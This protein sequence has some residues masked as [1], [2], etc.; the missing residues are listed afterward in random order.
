MQGHVAV[1]RH[2]IAV[3]VDISARD[4]V[5]DSSLLNACLLQ[6]RICVQERSTPLHLAC[7][8][9]HLDVVQV[10]LDNDALTHVEDK[11]GRTPLHIAR[12]HD[13][14]DIVTA[15][16]HSIARASHSSKVATLE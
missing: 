1:V 7:D 12:A 16:N 2:L 13:N 3:N 9:G 4:Q 8:G 5:R 10:L 14:S 15:L 11:E 6:V